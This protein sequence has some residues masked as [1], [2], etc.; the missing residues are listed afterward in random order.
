[1]RLGLRCA[2]QPTEGLTLPLTVR[3]IFDS[4][5][6]RPSTSLRWRTPLPDS[7][8]APGVYVVALT[9][10][11][12]EEGGLAQAPISA[13][14]IANLLAVRPELKVRGYRPTVEQLSAALADMWVPEVAVIYGG[15]AGTSLR[16]RVGQY[17]RT[18]LGARSP[19]AGGWPL[20]TLTNLTDM[21]VHFA[22]CDD[23]AW[24][25]TIMLDAFMA[26]VPDA[27]S[28]RLSDPLLPLPFANL[29]DGRHRRKQ[30]G[31][32]GACVPR[33]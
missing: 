14:A 12:D 28:S 17:Y 20:K 24:A 8:D 3:S 33:R 13:Q 25:E 16:T 32:R 2:E 29:E 6:L 23:P 11:I 30:H 1:V 18:S 22:T 9:G 10:D 26:Q 4:A 15:K 7:A 21:R 27:I 19:H 31:I 5:G